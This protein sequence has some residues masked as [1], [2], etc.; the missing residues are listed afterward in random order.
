MKGLQHTDRVEAYTQ[1]YPTVDRMFVEANSNSTEIIDAVPALAKVKPYFLSH[2]PFM[3]KTYVCSGTFK[4]F[5]NENSRPYIG[6][7]IRDTVS[8]D[9][10]GYRTSGKHFLP[11]HESVTDTE[12]GSASWVGKYAYLIVAGEDWGVTA[13][14]TGFDH[15]CIGRFTDRYYFRPNGIRWGDRFAKVELDPSLS[16]M[17]ESFTIT[18]NSSAGCCFGSCKVSA[19]P[20]VKNARGKSVTINANAYSLNPIYEIEKV[21]WCWTGATETIT[22]GGDTITQPKADK[23]TKTSI[24]TI[25]FDSYGTKTVTIRV[26][27]A[28]DG[29]CGCGCGDNSCCVVKD[30]VI[31][32]QP[33]TSSVCINGSIGSGSG[34]AG[35]GVAVPTTNNYK[36]FYSYTDATV[37]T[38]D[39][40][41]TMTTEVG[42]VTFGTAINIDD[43]A[44]VEAAVVDVLDTHGIAYT[45]IT[46]DYSPAANDGET[47]VLGIIV[48]GADKELISLGTNLDGVTTETATF[49]VI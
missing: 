2:F 49:S 17:N 8:G 25:L 42:T 34:S 37:A 41:K 29:E 38:Q 45:S 21:E 39:V 23:V 24:N 9:L 48:M 18:D 46:V 20:S 10:A 7:L 26:F 35:G 5:N 30:F 12:Y 28:K 13:D 43:T 1:Y 44:A 22:V 32:V 4:V 47:A 31:E 33:S 6:V 40:I 19:F 14:P 36:L 15:M 16:T 3:G 11:V 27:L